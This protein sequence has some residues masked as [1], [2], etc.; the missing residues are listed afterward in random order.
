[1]NDGKANIALIRHVTR[2]IDEFL[3]EYEPENFATV[4]EMLEAFSR[5]L[6]DREKSAA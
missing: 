6:M 1:M 4:G 5:W 2:R 3:Y